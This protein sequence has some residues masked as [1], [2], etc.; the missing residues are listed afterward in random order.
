MIRMQLNFEHVE[1]WYVLCSVVNKSKDEKQ[2]KMHIKQSVVL[3]YFI[4][5]LFFRFYC[6][7]LLSLSGFFYEFVLANIVVLFVKFET[8]YPLILFTLKLRVNMS[9]KS[10][11]SMPQ[12]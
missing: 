4:I 6:K 1:E 9:R 12:V 8:V 10:I 5:V 3:L 11:I 7:Q 2:I